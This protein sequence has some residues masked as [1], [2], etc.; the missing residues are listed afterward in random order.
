M[1]Y[2][3]RFYAITAA[4]ASAMCVMGGRASWG[5]TESPRPGEGTATPPNAPRQ[6]PIEVPR[7][8]PRTLRVIPDTS[9]ESGLQDEVRVPKEGLD[10][11][12]YLGGPEALAEAP[13]TPSNR[14]STGGNSALG[15]TSNPYIDNAVPLNRLMVRYDAADNNNFPDRAE[16]FYPQNGPMR[17]GGQPLNFQQQSTYL[18][19][20]PLPNLS[21]FFEV[22][23]RWVHIPPSTVP[24][25]RQAQQN[26]S[27]FSDLQMGFKY[28]FFTDPDYFYS[29]QLR[30]YLPTGNGATGLGTDHASLE[31]GLLAFQRLSE[32][33]FAVGE[34]KDWIP[35]HGSLNEVK[36]SP[37]FGQH[38]AGN[39][40]NYGVGLTYNLLVTDRY[41][42]APST[43]FVGWTVLGGLKETQTGTLVPAS[44]DTIVNFKVGA[45]VALGNYLSPTG[46]TPLNDRLSL[47]T[48]YSRALTGDWWYR[49]M[50]RVELSWYY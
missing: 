2:R 31:P 37:T 1:F 17:N 9:P 24:N 23:V 15:G 39:V 34:F 44:G 33:L 6:V 29:F 4:M 16:F 27:G 36:G 20:A 35:I 50:L 32:R 14:P 21:G 8:R 26:F 38:F 28:A 12:L 19:Y 41:R 42:V 30:T 45:T 49:D 22:P 10:L 7:D 43:E 47:Y 46:P 13:I 18:E 25:H 48:G 5:Q 3:A 40:L 11:N